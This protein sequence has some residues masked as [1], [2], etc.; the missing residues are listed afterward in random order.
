[1]QGA[2]CYTVQAG[3]HPA[4]LVTGPSATLIHLQAPLGVLCRQRSRH[5]DGPTL[6]NPRSKV[7]LCWGL[8]TLL[9]LSMEGRT[10]VSG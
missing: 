3:C 8:T 2:L 1:M 4:T 9:L 5:L 7:G 6:P 10:L